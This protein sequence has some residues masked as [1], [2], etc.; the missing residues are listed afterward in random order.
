MQQSRVCT[1]VWYSVVSHKRMTTIKRTSKIFCI[2]APPPRCSHPV[3]ETH[4]KGD[5]SLFIVGCAIINNEPAPR[6]H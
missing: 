6:P 3:C 1:S 5:D 4:F 2:Q